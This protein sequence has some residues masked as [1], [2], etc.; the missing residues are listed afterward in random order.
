[1]DIEDNFFYKG[2]GQAEYRRCSPGSA[3]HK[4]EGP[5]QGMTIKSSLGCGV[6][7][8]SAQDA[9]GKGAAVFTGEAGTTMMG[10][11][12]RQQVSLK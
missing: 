8:R 5:G 7:D 6:R 12:L 4:Q 1:M 11:F 3:T 9:Q 10:I 2:A